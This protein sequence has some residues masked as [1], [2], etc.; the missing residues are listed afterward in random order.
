[1]NDSS[2]WIKIHR[3]ILDHWIWKDRIKFGWWL[4]L[5]FMANWEQKKVLVGNTLITIERGQM[6][7]SNSFLMEKWG[8][9]THTVRNFLRLLEA[10]G[11]ITQTTY[12]KFNIITICNYDKYQCNDSKKIDPNDDLYNDP[13]PTPSADPIA[14]PKKEYK[15]ERSK[16]EKEDTNV[17]SKKKF[18]FRKE[19]I[20][21]GVEENIADD[22]LKIRKAKRASDSETAFK[23]LQ[24]AIRTIQIQN[25]LTANDII[26]ICVTNGWYGCKVSYF[27]NIR[28][29]DYDLT[30]S[31]TQQD[32]FSATNEASQEAV[33][34]W[35]VKYQ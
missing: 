24:T 8:V 29:N 22:W 26:K 4:E 3:S 23:Q 34:P 35:G 5:L 17:S 6:I 20:A 32:L 31:G 12:P 13:N 2:G 33:S 28:L 27:S 14:D 21:L 19:L 15:K 7:A 25:G 30:T 11:M 10:D 1:M 9:C 18:L 16:E